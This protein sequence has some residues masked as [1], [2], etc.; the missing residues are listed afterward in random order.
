MTDE[1]SGAKALPGLGFETM[2]QGGALR[3][4]AAVVSPQLALTAE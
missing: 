2:M 3:A 1:K 4:I